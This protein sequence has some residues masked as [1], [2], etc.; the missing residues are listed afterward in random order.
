MFSFSNK[1]AQACISIPETLSVAGGWRTLIGQAEPCP[2]SWEPSQFIYT[3]ET[4]PLMPT[5]PYAHLT[6]T[7][8][9]CLFQ[10]LAAPRRK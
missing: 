7:L 10:L 3:T 9:P 8:L 5:I 6:S 1:T 2:H 4:R